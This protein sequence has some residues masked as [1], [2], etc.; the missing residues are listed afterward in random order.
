MT[1]S[2]PRVY[3]DPEIADLIP[4]FLASVVESVDIATSALA[5]GDFERIRVVGHNLRGSGGGFGFFPI[6]R[7]GGMVEDAARERDADAIAAGLR[8]LTRYV[9]AVEVVYP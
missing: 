7:Y 1:S 5:D 8:K 9:E 6:T 2:P 4:E 3:A